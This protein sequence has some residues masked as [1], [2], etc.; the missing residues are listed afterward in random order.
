MSHQSRGQIAVAI[1]FEW[2]RIRPDLK[3]TPAQSHKSLLDAVAEICGLSNVESLDDITDKELSIVLEALVRTGRPVPATPD[4][5]KGRR[6]SRH[7]SGGKFE[8]FSKEA[9]VAALNRWDQA[10]AFWPS[11]VSRFTGLC[12]LDEMILAAKALQVASKAYRSAS[13]EGTKALETKPRSGSTRAQ[14]WKNYIGRVNAAARKVE[15]ARRCYER[16]LARFNRAK[17]MVGPS[18]D[19]A[20]ALG[21]A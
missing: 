16:E 11:S 5:A 9:L 20:K 14:A 1:Q 10:G 19:K 17:E 4:P 6:K 18:D 15:R 3:G 7:G 13:D 12:W 8:E 21:D 2:A